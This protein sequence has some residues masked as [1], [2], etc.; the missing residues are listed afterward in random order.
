MRR[1][2]KKRTKMTPYRTRRKTL[3]YSREPD[4]KNIRRSGP[5]EEKRQEKTLQNPSRNP[6]WEPSALQSSDR[7]RSDR[8]TDRIRIYSA[9]RRVRCCQEGTESRFFSGQGF[10]SGGNSG[11]LLF[12]TKPSGDRESDRKK[13]QPVYHPTICDAVGGSRKDGYD[14]VGE[15][16][17]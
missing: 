11:L 5:Q 12:S 6:P 3:R 2:G 15:A 8:K 9:D 7:I 13:D 17:K 14:T 16:E 1:N 4:R 10:C